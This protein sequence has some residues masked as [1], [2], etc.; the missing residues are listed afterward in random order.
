MWCQKLGLDQA[1][2]SLQVS[3]RGQDLYYQ[4]QLIVVV[5]LT[6][7]GATALGDKPCKRPELDVFRRGNYRFQLGRGLDTLS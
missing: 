1:V 6:V 2:Y 7:F 5:T 4:P 3:E